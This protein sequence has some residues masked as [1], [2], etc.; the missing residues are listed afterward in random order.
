MTENIHAPETH[1]E[2]QKLQNAD[3]QSIAT[4]TDDYLHRLKSIYDS[5][6]YSIAVL[7][8]IRRQ[9]NK[10]FGQFLKKNAKLVSQV[11]AKQT[12]EVPHDKIDQANR[13]ERRVNQFVNGILIMPRT[14]LVAFLSQ[15]DFFLGRLVRHFF[16]I[17]PE[18]INS[19]DKQ[20]RLS[21]LLE[22]N[23]IDDAKESLI[24]SEIETLL[25]K[26]HE[27]QFEWLE[28]KYGLPLRTGLKS[29][30]QFV[31]L[32]Q[33]RNLYVHCD[34]IVSRQYIRACET[35]GVSFDEK[36]KIGSRLEC[37]PQYIRECY[38]CL[39]EIG[40]KLSQVLW[41]KLCQE[42]IEHA[43][44]SLTI[45]SYELLKSG[46]YRLLIRVIDHFTSAPI[47]YSSEEHRRIL[48]INH[49]IALQHSDQINSS[50]TL[51]NKFDWTACSHKFQLAIAILNDNRE[52][53]A[54][55]MRKIGKDGEVT[56]E[57]YQAWPLFRKLHKCDLFLNTYKEIFNKDYVHTPVT[58]EKI[59]LA[60]AIPS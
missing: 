15:Y 4:I 55:I 51:L 5:L 16:L 59:N 14:T 42:Q 38:E 49:A 7:D 52:K 27:E 26:S 2:L 40:A 41:R 37:T 23:S 10:E 24:E 28:K 57:N 12:F 56:D 47:K 25:R 45:L 32:T 46:E 3:E 22:F 11:G 1:A 35:A 19:L 50:I 30:P 31:E 60:I 58:P 20:I 8:A 44:E 21:D 39:F 6:P 36:P 18:L 17:K 33:R 48:I 29:W 53:A 43:D 9:E 13:L 54:C 34:G